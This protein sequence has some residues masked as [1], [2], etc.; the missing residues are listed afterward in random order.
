MEDWPDISQI[1]GPCITEDTALVFHAM[2]GLPGPYIKDFM[3]NIGHAGEILSSH[4]TEANTNAFKTR[5]ERNAGRVSHK[6]RDGDM[7]IRIQ[8]RS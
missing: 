2:N 3:K 5:F 1:D 6:R 4:W 7:H 8:P